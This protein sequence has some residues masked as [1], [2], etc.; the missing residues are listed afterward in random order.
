MT[1]PLPIG[2]LISG[3]GSN[4]Q[5]IIDAVAKRELT[6]RI[7][8]VISNRADAYGLVRARQQGIPTA[9]F[10][11]KEFSSREAFE[12]ALIQCLQAHRVELVALAGFMR[13]LTPFFVHAFPQRIMNIHPALLPAFPGIQAQRQA[14][15]YGA[16]VTGATV[17]FVDEEMDHGPIITQAA[18]PVYPDDT[19]EALSARILT[20]EHRLYPQAIQLFAEGRLEIRGR[21]VVVHSEPRAPHAALRVPESG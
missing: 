4:L 6:A 3:S 19:E 16:R 21:G 8:V 2:V 15:Q 13:V 18:V 11:H 1:S 12:A 7:Q 5:A 14:L 20:Q 17:H 9:V 10:T